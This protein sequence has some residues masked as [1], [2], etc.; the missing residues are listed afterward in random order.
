MRTKKFNA[1]VAGAVWR[2]L[3]DA[4]TAAI[5]EVNTARVT[6]SAVV[7]EWAADSG[8]EAA[9]VQLA[10]LDELERKAALRL[11][12]EQSFLKWYFD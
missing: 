5:R 6:V 3:N 9:Q 4:S 11:Q 10:R 2:G 7:H 8:R 12:E 1:E